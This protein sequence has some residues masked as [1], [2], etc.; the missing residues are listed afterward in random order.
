MSARVTMLAMAMIGGI[1]GIA[2][3]TLLAIAV[4]Y[5]SD[6][7]LPIEWPKSPELHRMMEK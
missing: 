3:G 7:Q 2:A 1:L 4:S 5:R 6:G